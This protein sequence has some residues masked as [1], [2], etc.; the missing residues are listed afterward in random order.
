MVL[1]IG[2]KNEGVYR[3]DGQ[4]LY[5]LEFPKH[6][7][8]DK[9]Y[10]R[11]VNSFFSPYEVYSIYKDR[12]GAIWFGT[13]VFGACR[14]DGETV[15]WMYEDDLTYV[16]NGGTFGIRSILRTK[17][18]VFGFATHGTD[19]FS[20]WRKL[21]LA[22]DFSIRKLVELET[23]KYLVGMNIFIFLHFRR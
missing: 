12:K 1:Y 15:K 17:K 22:I 13:S 4:K 7:L 2:K 5:D 18:A 8:H 10:P 6:Y 20:T 11:V 21:K 9:I 14:F 19:I 3:Y 16:P 23:R